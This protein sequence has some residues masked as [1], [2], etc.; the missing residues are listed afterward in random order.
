MEASISEQSER[1]QKQETKNPVNDGLFIDKKSGKQFRLFKYFDHIVVQDVAN[2]RI[3][4]SK[5]IV[6][7]TP[8]GRKNPRDI[9]D[10]KRSGD[11]YRLVLEI[12]KEMLLKEFSKKARKSSISNDSQEVKSPEISGDL[13]HQEIFPSLSQIEKFIF[14]EYN[15]G[16]G[17]EFIH[18]TF[19]PFKAFQIIALWA[20]KTHKL[21]VLDL[22]AKINEKA[23]LDGRSAYD[24]MEDIS[25]KLQDEIEKLSKEK[26]KLQ[27]QLNETSKQLEEFNKPFNKLVSPSIIWFKHIGDDYFHMT[28]SRDS[29]SPQDAFK[30]MPLINARD[31]KEE[32]M[33][34]LEKEG[35]VE[36]IDRKCLIKN[37]RLEYVCGL[38]E[39]ISR[40]DN[41]T[42]PSNEERLQFI[43]E[44]LQDLQSKPFTAQNEGFIYELEIIRSREKYIPWKMLPR[45]VRY[46][47]NE[48]SRD[49]GIDAVEL[50]EKGEILSIIQIKHHR[51]SYLRK[52]EVQ[53]FM[54]KCQDERYKNLEK[55]LIIHGCKL[56][57]KLRLWIEASGVVIEVLGQDS[58]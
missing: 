45:D 19:V 4:V 8:S 13:E 56:S 3:N 42:K 7:T 48:K 51:E 2:G 14:Q 33:K 36:H 39:E 43:D 16:Y 27:I 15:Q 57:K 23:N 46:R 11:D 53:C 26:D 49:K 40:C 24:E 35:L 34:Q 28:Y 52:D 5:F 38:I 29:S 20:D 1:I 18:G 41:F 12:G 30:V 32:L 21:A 17:T 10:F 47:Q 50:S 31:V 6:L 54:E 37:E 44:K 58:K 25:N 55:R 22:I 9:S